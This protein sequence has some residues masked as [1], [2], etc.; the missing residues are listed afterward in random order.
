MKKNDLDSLTNLLRSR[1]FPKTQK[2]SDAKVKETSMYPKS[3]LSLKTQ[4]SPRIAI[5]NE[6]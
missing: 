1:I 5:G 3:K 4:Y 6:K 2:R